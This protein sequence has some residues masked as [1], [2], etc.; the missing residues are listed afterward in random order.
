[1]EVHLNTKGLPLYTRAVITIG[2]F[3]GV[4][5]GHRTIID[6]VV[7][8]AAAVQGQSVLITFDP[9][10]RKIVKPLEPLGLINTL[11]EKIDLLQH[12]GLT[13]MVVVPFTASFAEQPAQDYIKKFLVDVFHP[14][15]I[16][17]GYDHHFGKG[18]SGNIALLQQYASAYN[19]EVVE[20]PKHVI[21]EVDI[22]STQIRKALMAGEVE[23]ANKLLGYA[24]HFSGLVVRGDQIGRTL[25]YPTAN[26]ELTNQ[27]KIH[28]GE[29]VFTATVTHENHTYKGMLS[30]GKRPTLNDVVERIEVNLFEFN[31]DL[32][33]KELKVTVHHRIRGQEK[34]NS[35]EA[36]K[37]QMDK[38]KATTEQL[39]FNW[40][41]S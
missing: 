4:H 39:L 13:A 33:G 8:Q 6:A 18:R 21:D 25:G 20:I 31:G 23:R 28:L 40:T 17:I 37:Q 38:D 19:Y 22:S 15:T 32:Y 41:T 16:I 2:T 36:L 9:H 35:L 5:L 1:M 24:F 12:T 29:G 27:D 14:H 11:Q 26:I 3:D 10:P 7:Q 30:I 34:F